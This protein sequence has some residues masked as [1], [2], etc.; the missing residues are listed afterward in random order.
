M[1][2]AKRTVVINRPVS[3]V[4]G[5]FTDPANDPRWRVHVKEIRADGPPE[6]GRRIHQVLAGPAGRRI[7]ADLE[8]TAYEPPSHYAFAVVAG[9]ARPLGDFHFRSRADGG[10]DVTFA[11]RAELSGVKKLI[12]S[13][14]VQKSMDGE[15]ANL[16]RAKL[17]LEA[18]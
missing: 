11:L 13:R 5:F 2:E 12:M 16:D 14:P 18:S 17:L 6:V 4:F 7:P 3:E 1:P 8:V 15:V 9:L 10:T